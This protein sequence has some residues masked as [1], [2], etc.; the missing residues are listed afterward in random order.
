MNIQRVKQ[1]AKITLY[2]GVFMIIFGLYTI[3][4]SEFNMKN[5]FTAISGIWILF[6][7]YNPKISVLF[8]LLNI[9]IGIFLISFGIIIIYLS[10]FIIKRKEKI[11]WVV[12][13]FSGIIA[14]G[15]LLIINILIKNI[16][17]IILS[18]IGWLSFV[19]GMF[20][21]IRY[22]LEKKYREY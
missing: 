17:L 12:M 7:K 14:W 20:I 9:I 6:A 5:S 4:F 21:P 13:F 22:Y 11:T 3:F 15:G 18:F 19:I 10:Y 8:I 2:N 16:F 1:G